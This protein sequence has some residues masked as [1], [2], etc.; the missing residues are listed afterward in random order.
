MDDDCGWHRR[1]F[2][3]VTGASA[4]GLAGCSGGGSARTPTAGEPTPGPTTQSTPADTATPADESGATDGVKRMEAELADASLEG[5]YVDTH[6]HW[7]RGQD[8]VVSAYADRMAEYDI[9]ATAL[10]SPSRAAEAGYERFLRTLTEPGVDY[11]PF[12]SA[13]PPGR[14]L[15]TSLRSLYEDTGP[16]FWGVGEWKPQQQPAPDF[17]GDRLA[18]LWELAADLDIPVMYHPFPG[19]EGQVEAAI[20]AH[21]ET[22]FLLHGHQMMGYGQD[23]P[24]LGPTLPRLLA[25]Y[26]NLYWTVDVAT[27]TDGS[28][29]AFQGPREFHEWYEAN[30]AEMAELF[31]NILADLLEAGPAQVVWGTDVAWEWNLESEV[32]SRV[33]D[34]TEQV[35]AGVPEKHHAA[36]KRENAVDLFAR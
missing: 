23:R 30:A 25:E 7:Q 34:F 35:L 12:M 16:A 20:A 3:A 15:P 22:T 17:D 13:P 6:A 4:V 31:G 1:A 18:G 19:Q 27:M 26:D 33:M 14:N 9:G 24:G 21:P 8:G 29:V 10:F 11:L 28:L 2:L 32:F 36:Y 5:E